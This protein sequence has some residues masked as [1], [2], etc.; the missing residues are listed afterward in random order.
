MLPERQDAGRALSAEEESA[1]LLECGRSRSRILLPFVV[2]ALEG[3]RF[4]TIRTLQWKNINLGNR[5]L[6]FGKDKTTAGT[7]RL[8]P[9]NQ[10]ALAALTFWAQQ[11]PNRGP[12]HYVFPL[13]KCTGAGTKGSFGFTGTLVTTLIR[14]N[15]SAT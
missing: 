13:E 5:C 11:F 8:V 3:A 10:R 15:P 14:R 7:G 1:L 4:N 9:L 2:L 6:Q 12:E